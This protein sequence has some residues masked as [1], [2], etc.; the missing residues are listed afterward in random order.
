M[1]TVKQAKYIDDFKIWLQFSD[2]AEG[3]A[4]FEQLLD[5]YAAAKPLKDKTEFQKF[6]LD[7][8]PTLTWPC[9]FDYSPE[10]LYSLAT[11]RTYI[12]S[13]LEGEAQ[14]PS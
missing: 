5:R 11:G 13:M 4:D 12:W 6:Y 10:G 9:G 1:I 7:E 3:V 2:G 14:E 8:W